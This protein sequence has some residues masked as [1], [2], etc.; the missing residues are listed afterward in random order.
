MCS[1][2]AVKEGMKTAQAHTRDC[3]LMDHCVK[4]GYG[5]YTK[6][7]KFLSFD[8]AGNQKALAALKASKKKAD[9]QVK[10]TGDISGDLI[11]VTDLKLL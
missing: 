5:V 11:K 7:G 1:D 3:A 2:Q 6:D 8:A 9:L 4:A 10:V